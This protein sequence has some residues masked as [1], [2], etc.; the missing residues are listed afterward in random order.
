MRNEFTF[1]TKIKKFDYYRVQ[2]DNVLVFSPR[3]T[4]NTL[5]FRL[6]DYQVS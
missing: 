5:N 6:E 2:K 3:S 1:K 4:Y